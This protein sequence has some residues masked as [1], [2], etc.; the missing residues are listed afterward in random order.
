M[1]RSAAR[2]GATGTRRSTVSYPIKY[3]P[4][5]NINI[6][7]QVRRD[8]DPTG[9]SELA[10]K[11]RK[12]EVGIFS[13]PGVV[14]FD[15]QTTRLH[16]QT[17]AELY[18]DAQV[19][20][21]GLVSNSDGT[22]TL[23]VWGHRR[24]AACRLL[25]SEIGESEDVPAGLLFEK[26]V[27]KVAVREREPAATSDQALILQFLENTYEP[28]NPVDVWEFLSAYHRFM[29]R[30]KGQEVSYAETA[31]ALGTRADR[32]SDAVHFIDLPPTIRAMTRNGGLPLGGALALRKLIAAGW[33]E[34]RILDWI[35]SISATNG[36]QLSV[37]KVTQQ[38]K[39]AL[40]RERVESEGQLDLL[41]IMRSAADEAKN[42]HLARRKQA[43]H[44]S[45]ALR[46][47]LGFVRRIT[48]TSR[49]RPDMSPFTDRAT[50]STIAQIVRDV[51]RTAPVLEEVERLLAVVNLREQLEALLDQAERLGGRHDYVSASPMSEAIGEALL[52]LDHA[53]PLLPEATANSIESKL[54]G[55]K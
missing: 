17:L 51:L 41:D 2:T 47:F 3:V 8:M 11:I 42:G 23:A 36:I 27:W 4:I 43:R 35:S 7:A 26:G 18:P 5:R 38:V 13:E 22:Y 30:L 45:A 53:R 21:E 40:A 12:Q 54:T 10:S 39:A 32:V 37:G 48:V 50:A 19:S 52:A 20:F 1:G 14:T 55:V 16:I 25:V 9:V 34:S 46:E 24:L 6:V 29:K 15:A 31:R 49:D 44:T 33:E 28:P